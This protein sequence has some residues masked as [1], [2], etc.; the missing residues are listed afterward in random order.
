MILETSDLWLFSVSFAEL[1]TPGGLCLWSSCFLLTPQNLASSPFR[2]GT[3]YTSV[4]GRREEGGV[5]SSRD[6][7][8]ARAAPGGWSGRNY[9]EV[10]GYRYSR[11]RP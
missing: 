8:R 4:S 3:Q 2:E 10:S 9:V 11:V 7:A 1:T 6:P 5:G